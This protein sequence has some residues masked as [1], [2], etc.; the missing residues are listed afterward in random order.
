MIV[1]GGYNVYPREVEDA[2]LAVDGVAEAAVFGVAHPLWGEAVV[3][4]LCGE[5]RLDEARILAALRERLAAYKLPKRILQ[6]DALPRNA[7]GK[8][9]KQALRTEH[10]GLFAGI[11]D[12]GGG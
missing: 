9:Q 8:V 2:L 12:G 6:V 3:A 7:M 5:G 10:A 1:T 11:G 4:T